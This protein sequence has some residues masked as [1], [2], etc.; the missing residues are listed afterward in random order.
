MYQSVNLSR[1]HLEFRREIKTEIDCETIQLLFLLLF[2]HPDI[3]FPT[4]IPPRPRRSRRNI[5]DEF[6]NSRVPQNKTQSIPPGLKS[7]QRR[8]LLLPRL[9]TFL[10]P[11]LRSSVRRFVAP[12]IVSCEPELPAA[13]LTSFPFLCVGRGEEM[14]RSEIQ[15]EIEFRFACCWFA[16]SEGVVQRWTEATDLCRV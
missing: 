3:P 15:S 2:D 5:L 11:F 16:T 12:F 8:V 6:Q 13:F 1:K 10:V 14:Y 9:T 7:Q 4:N